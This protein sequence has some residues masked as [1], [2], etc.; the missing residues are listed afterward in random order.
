MKSE[1]R[2]ELQHNALADW[3]ETTVESFK[4]Y[5]NAILGGVLAVVVLAAATALWVR[6][7]QRSAA[8]AWGA[9]YTAM[10]A[11]SVADLE[12]VAKNFASTKAGQWASVTAADYHLI[13]GCDTIL[14]DKTK[15]KLDLKRAIDDYEIAAKSG[16]AEIRGRS[17][18]GLG[19]AHE[20]L[21][22]LPNAV[23]EYQKV[24]DQYGAMAFA[25]EAK[26]R[27]KMLQDESTRK[28]YDQL[29]KFEPKPPEKAQSKLPFDVGTLNEPPVGKPAAKADA[30]PADAKPAETK[31]AEPKPAEKK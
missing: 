9:Y 23:K 2:H 30:K 18:F 10:N 12:T 25:A 16:V 7:S 11:R 27:V 29:D 14:S 31:P 22:D 15:A 13:Q 3:L 4:P 28:F 26:Q 19:Q 8:D 24:V 20:T 17:A 21:G 1:R 5:S 6:F